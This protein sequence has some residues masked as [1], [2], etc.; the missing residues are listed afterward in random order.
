MKKSG[1]VRR[2]FAMLL[3]LMMVLQLVPATRSRAAINDIATGNKGGDLGFD[4]STFNQEGAINWPIKIYD[5]L[6]DG[7]LF[8]FAN[9]LSGSM[10]DSTNDELGGGAA[11][12]GGEKMPVTMIGTDYTVAAAYTETAYKNHANYNR[13]N[14]YTLTPM[15][16]TAWKEPRHLRVTA[17]TTGGENM[18]IEVSNF[19]SDNGKAMKTTDIRYMTIVYRAKNVSNTVTRVMAQYA[20]SATY[21][22]SLAMP[23]LQE[24]SEFVYR[25]IDLREAWGAST[26]DSFS[27]FYGLWL[28]IEGLSGSGQVDLTHVAY[29]DNEKEAV[30]YGQAAAAFSNKPG[31]DLNVPVTI[32][33]GTYP[34]VSKPDRLFSLRRHYKTQNDTTSSNLIEN[35]G[36]YGLDFT[37]KSTSGG[38]YTTGFN[39]STYKTWSSGTT[40]SVPYGSKTNSFTMSTITV[41][42]KTEKNGA[43]YL[44][45]TNSAASNMLLTTFRE[46]SS[47]NTD[48]PAI[49]DVNYVVLVYRGN[50]MTN[51]RY[52]F[53]AQGTNSA[54]TGYY[55][56]L[57]SSTSSW[58][59]SSYTRSKAF[60]I[61]GGTW[62][63][64]MVDLS[65]TIGD[66]DSDVYDIDNLKRVGLYLPALSGGVSLDL[67]YVAYFGD[68]ATASS[69]GSN[70]AAYM[71]S[72][73]TGGGTVVSDRGWN[74][75]NNQNFGMLFASS[76]GSWGDAQNTS[77]TAGGPNA[78]PNGYYSWMIGYNTTYE[79]TAAHNAFRQDIYGNKYTA[80]HTNAS[81]VTQSSVKGSSDPSS[82]SYSNHIYYI[83]ANY[84]ND[85]LG[86]DGYNTSVLQFDGY[87]LQQVIT[88]GLMTAGLLEGSLSENRTPVYRQETVEYIAMTLYN[89]LTIP[90]KDGKGNYNYNYISGGT[91]KQYG[92]YDLNRDGKIGMADLN[93]DGYE[94]TN[95][96]NCDLATALRYCLGITFTAGKD[97]GTYPTLGNFATTNSKGSKLIGKFQDVRGNI[98]T[99]MDAA[100]FLLNN[101]F[102][103]DS[104]NQ[105]QDDYGYL[106]LAGVTM[107]NG[108]FAYIFDAG[109]TTG[110]QGNETSSGYKESSQS[111]IKY[112]PYETVDK[113]GNISFGGGTIAMEN[114]NSKDLYYYQT[115]S[116]TTRF[117]FLPITDSEGDYA[118]ESTSYY[119]CD[120]GIRVYTDEFGTYQDRNY[121]YVLASNGE[122]VYR[123]GDDLFFQF[124]GDDDVYLFINGQIVLDIGAAHSI[125]SAGIDVNEYVHQ[126]RKAMAALE[127]Y[128]YYA[129]MPNSAFDAMIDGSTLT[130]YTF[131]S[132]GDVIDQTTVTNPYSEEERVMLK[133]YH[134]L[135]LVEG[136]ICQF[137]FFYM[138][139]HG[140][141]AN[142]RIVTNMHITDPTLDVSK[143]A[144]QFGEEIEYGG[145]V[146]AAS[147]MEYYFQLSN[148]GNTKLYNMTFTDTTI[149][150]K[151]DYTNG[152]M[153][154]SKMNGL[155]VLDK[156]GGKLDASDLYAV[157]KGYRPT[158]NGK[159]A[160][161]NATGEYVAVSDPSMGT[162]DYVE[163]TVYFADND[164]LIAFL[165]RLEG[166]GME[167]STTSEEITQAG[168]GLWVDSTVQIRGIHYILTPVQVEA[169]MVNNTV[170]VTATTRIDP[171]TPGNETLRSDAS[172]RA[173]T[174]GSAVYYQWAGHELFLTEQ[175]LLDDA[176]LEAGV[177]DSQLN[178]YYA[179]FSKIKGDTSRI[180]SR[181]CDKYG[182]VTK[183][184]EISIQQD[185]KGNDGFAMNFADAGKHNVYVLMHLNEDS[186]NVD[187]SGKHIG[188]GANATV[189]EMVLGSYA[190]VRVTVYSADVEDSYF[191]MDYGLKTESL[192]TNGEL[193]KNDYLFGYAGG[194]EAKLM[195]VT[196]VEPS[197]VSAVELKLSG[198][199]YV[200]YNRINFSP[201]DLSENKKLNPYTANGDPD[202]Y[203]NVN[204]A[205][206]STGKP[207]TYDS[208]TG[209]HSLVDP[210]TVTIT[211]EVPDNDN[212]QKV[213]LYYW[214]DNGVN[215]GWPGTA[216]TYVSPGRYQLDIPGDVTHV[217]INNGS[218]ALQTQDLSIAAGI[219]STIKIS[220]TNN[221]VS[222][223]VESA[224]K[225]VDVHVKVPDGWGKSYL[226]Y[227]YDDGSS[228]V[229][230]PG[231]ELTKTDDN[232]Y[233]ITQIPGGASYVVINNGK[234]NMK[235]TSDLDINAGHPVW[236]VVNTEARE[237]SGGINYYDADIVY[238]Q[239]RYTVKAKV[240]ESWG[241]TV[242][243][244]Y[245]YS[246]STSNPVSWPGITMTKDA[247]G[248]YTLDIS[249]GIKDVV[250][251]DGTSQTLDLTVQAGLETWITVN[252]DKMEDKGNWKHTATVHYGDASSNT[253]LFFTPTDFV[254][255]EQTIWLAITVH[256]TGF[257]P[258]ALSGN[259]GSGK[260]L[261]L[262]KEVQMF[263]KVTVLPANV[264]YY[265]DDFAGITYNNSGSNTF[266]HHG[267]GSVVLSQSV[268][269]DQNYGQDAA[270]QDEENDQFSGE[271]LTKVQITG[272]DKVATF[273]FTG[274]GFEIISRTNAQD[275]AS[276][277]IRLYEA[278]TYS[279]NAQ[280]DRVIP[281]ITQ[282]DNG[283][284]G[285]SE[286][287]DQVPVVRINDLEL[288]SYVVEIYGMPTYDFDNWNG[289]SAPALLRTYLY[290]DGIRVFQPMGE[291]HEQYIQSENGAQFD[292]I[293]DLVAGG[294]V[295]VV[296]M[297]D[298]RLTV[299]S[300]TTT[301]TE[302]LLGGQLTGYVGN[303]V[304]STN[305]YLIQ[306]PNNEV[307]MEGGVVNSAIILYVS[308]N[309]QY[310][311]HELQIA[312]RGLDQ[313]KFNGMTSTGVTAQLQYG[314]KSGS[315]FDW[316]NLALIESGT[317]QYY[318]IP[319]NMCPVDANGNYQIMIRAV[320]T[321]G[322][323]VM[324]SY[325]TV[326]TLG[327]D[328]QKV[329]GNGEA[330]ILYY[331]DGLLVRPTYSIFG[332]ID[333]KVVAST[334]NPAEQY[335]F[336]GDRLEITFS[337][338]S[339]I[340]IKSVMAGRTDLFMVDGTVGSSVTSATLTNINYIT[341]TKGMLTI[342]AGHTVTLRI[343]QTELGS[344]TLSYELK[345]DWDNGRITR[346]PTCTED[347]VAVYT[348]VTC[349]T[350]HTEAVSATGHNYVGGSCTNCGATDPN[351]APRIIYLRSGNGWGHPFVYTWSNG[352][353]EFTG[354]WPGSTMTQLGNSSLYFYVVPG[355]AENVIFTDGFNQ[356]GD[357]QLPKDG[358][359]LYILEENRWITY[360]P[361]CTH[362]SHS[363]NGFCNGCG[364][365][366]NHSFSNGLCACGASD[367][368]FAG[369]Y[370]VG[371]INGTD[372]GCEGDWANTGIYRFE[373]GSLVATFEQDSYVFV[374]TG[375]NSNWYMT[376]AYV[377][378]STGTFYPT[379]TG[380][381][382]KM[383]VPGGVPVTFSLIAN[384]D[385]TLTLS[386]VAA[387]SAMESRIVMNLDSI[388]LQMSAAPVA[389]VQKPEISLSHPSLSFEDEIRYN[390]YYNVS[391]LTNVV[392]MGLITFDSKLTD[393]TVA[394]AKEIIPGYTGNGSLFMSATNGIAPKNMGDT[395]YFKV[396][397]KLS[398]GS[399]VYSNMAGYNAVAY[400][401]TVL[402]G[403]DETAKALVIAMLNYGA[404]AQQY[405]G[406]KTDELMNAGLTAGQYDAATISNVVKAD[407]S[408]LGAFTANGGFNKAY[409]TVSFEGAFA[410]NYYLTPAKSVDNGMILYYWD[411]DAY[412]SADALTVDNATGA[413][414]MTAG[415]AYWGVIGGIA[416]KDMDETIYVAAVYTS[417]GET[418]CSGVIAY[419]LGRYL[420]TVAADDT[421]DAQALAQAAAIYGTC[422]KNFFA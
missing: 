50:N 24:S 174:S 353:G 196:N 279:A 335:V 141:G 326:K 64:A 9:G 317:E 3:A 249:D 108:Q 403:N 95:E 1:F 296:E 325:T 77:T 374:K 167:T 13:G 213:S 254:D 278:A 224:V 140:N 270:Y 342:P 269:Q 70:A 136:Q 53:W 117:P 181:L 197:Y 109:F 260:N 12:G 78:D 67:A 252:E 352:G 139:R 257:R 2:G 100:Y 186:R 158:K 23:A 48:A 297:N 399:Y 61:T 344:L 419:S 263:K 298:D 221:K 255:S 60:D 206:P 406:Y 185:G 324:V 201:A 233:F 256:N 349:G 30:N 74:M 209:Q 120:D 322:K 184:P 294:Q 251:T 307:Y 401:N 31:E 237:Q 40:L 97:R 111:A 93:G 343:L 159:F 232:G 212:W 355:Q 300:G 402:K 284:N 80:K 421:S 85:N 11:Y 364:I 262:N 231:V 407:A 360:N 8:E 411:A 247:N 268:D 72:G 170:Y 321:S 319:Y 128:G 35:V 346:Y 123:E 16:A 84:S 62:T 102:V 301:W 116:V 71:N 281:V 142:M 68:S 379:S 248:W 378:G 145:V 266:T 152:L 240:P 261:N 394:D 188:Y 18:N 51:Q 28:R 369:Y 166:E 218:T 39:S 414:E 193:F 418:Q 81:A 286:G 350:T 309:K 91:S 25:V 131:N 253:G 202:G 32:G 183:Y 103:D 38:Y 271:S 211:A 58:L 225:E 387:A 87:N 63:Y 299:S 345:H 244:Y 90:Q 190:I 19:Y 289:V 312:V 220:V 400:A 89:A 275:S 412:A 339:Y 4:P 79:P 88:D 377:P 227:T 246:G 98:T 336:D 135:N 372:Y 361:N 242:Y 86:T 187:A 160:Y 199:T 176:T 189:S 303:K 315:G 161:N 17:G 182:R 239:D 363:V 222:A 194:M 234:D 285:G 330:S 203:F 265:E 410:M 173:Y 154:D 380:S 132:D 392:E 34:V 42:Q 358:S 198:K 49:S 291:V 76:G 7:M 26:F 230:W 318:S 351:T 329:A 47:S 357:M 306:G 388:R 241:D 238:S 272:T 385:G 341:G 178:Q 134:R 340:A 391:D 20:S 137:D 314:V 150:V 293:R 52:A 126:A 162:H 6:N 191:V 133:R 375:D 66:A 200:D 45:L 143:G 207:I 107:D 367:P 415:D 359:D 334:A 56:G 384:A 264:V 122:F 337:K 105:L 41:T 371:Y 172:H 393:G 245:W 292:E 169:G 216:M 331:S 149:G 5:Y 151:L 313:G 210:G 129:G 37:T 365:T 177:P 219:A 366:V 21:K 288:G 409:P 43:S 381:S 180:Y 397:A 323:P 55:A 119:F 405:F 106:T 179:F 99:C 82:S 138:E 92:G 287:I 195:G 148:T 175:K 348:C 259:P 250:I 362:S 96:A 73:L 125:T 54:G 146:D 389:V 15:A 229:A 155:Y 422:A 10:D 113:N 36:N 273:S 276:M 236:L 192:D 413:V 121:N 396:Y 320:S 168:S 164:A 338:T 65:A 208:Y 386:Y 22:T 368:T 305:D 153:V 101:I 33:G 44:R 370:L 416:A 27:S 94:E 290:L 165:N 390:V 69:F 376:Q 124:E 302:D 332:S 59:S 215:N 214:Y 14:Y 228:D 235:Q 408:K 223:T 127:K 327:M 147:S 267:N 118:G 217:I 205:F 277:V 356:T 171:M 163:Q 404:A 354:N 311:S 347:G 114:V 46:E 144:E 373:N 130:K 75:G 283:N 295:G 258:T 282:F 398:D 420:A 104:Y 156:H 110:I 308:E 112:S 417:Q 280:P 204:M 83:N 57:I 310:T 383:Y 29:F 304:T 333:G 226:Y 157:V 382:E 316:R 328:I 395:L 274:T 243:L 115:G